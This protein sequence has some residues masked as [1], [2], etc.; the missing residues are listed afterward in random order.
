MKTFVACLLVLTLVVP[1]VR[2]GDVP[3]RITY[4]GTLKQQGIPANGSKTMVFRLTNADGTVVYWSS[5]NVAVEVRQGLFSAV[6]NPSLD[7]QNADP[8][9]EVSVEGQTLL[10]REPVSS[11]AYALM[12]QSVVDGAIGIA[13]LDSG[14]KDRLIPS[15]MIGI[16]AT[17]CPDGWLY[18]ESLENRFPLGAR[19]YGAAGGSTTHDHG[20]WTGVAGINNNSD[21][22]HG[23]PTMQAHNHTIAAANHMPPYLGVIYCQKQ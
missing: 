6:L 7:W 14:A 9:V 10:P 2:A 5:S 4:Q 20:G 13:K 18:F 16:F 1:F 17:A 23:S 8:H 3:R 22:G 19:T 11:T 21:S 12:S 15:G